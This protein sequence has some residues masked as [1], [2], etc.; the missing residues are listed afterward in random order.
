MDIVLADHRGFCYGVRRAVAL[1]T[2]PPPRLPAYTLGPIIHNPQL[3]A[4]LARQGVRPVDSISDIPAGTVIFRSH[5]VAPSAYQ[6]AKERGL[7]VVDATCPHV[8]KAQQAVRAFVEQ[9]YQVVV[10]GE[11]AHPEV[12][13]VIAWAGQPVQVVETVEDAARLPAAPRLAVV[14]QTTINASLLAAVV[15]VLRP[16]CQDLQVSHTICQATSQRQQAARDLAS[17]V[18]V[19]V[20]IGGKNSANTTRLAEL[21]RATGTPTYHVETADELRPAWFAGVKRAGV[22]AGAST[23]DWIIEEV[24]GR[25]QDMDQIYDV[26]PLEKD[27]VIKGTVVSVS[28]EGVVVDTGHKEEGLIPLHE[29]AYPVPA[30]P[31][32]VVKPGDEIEVYV[33]STDNGE[34]NVLLS[35]VKA[36]AM[37]TWEALAAALDEHRPLT[38]QVTEVVKGG[39]SVAVMGVRGFIPASQVELHFVADLTPYVGQEVTALPIEVDTQ[40]HKVVLSRRRYLE[41]ERQ[42]KAQEVFASIEAGQTRKGIVRRLTDYGA[43]VDLGGVDGLLHVS[44]MSWERVKNPAD[45]ISVGDEID[46]YILKKDDATGRIS[47][48]LKQTQRNPWY[49]A[50]ADLASGQILTGTVTKTTSFGAFVKLPTGVEGLVHISQLAKRRVAT[51]EE[52]VKQGDTVK[53]KIL[54]IDRER[55]RISLSIKAAEDDDDRSSYRSYMAGQHNTRVTLGDTLG[56]LFEKKDD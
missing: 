42:K 4:R 47:L 46:V 1:A 45:V 32:A 43:F 35:K 20:V 29:L 52:V 3:V 41:E 15:E 49:D 55:Q 39:L 14:A 36:D 56:H 30:D 26:K 28:N 44:E 31:A 13:S 12:Q 24:I 51:T 5:G 34:G 21:C 50:V 6:Q 18:E 25:M 8:R 9:G 38:C 17:Q 53:V 10:V 54:G 19:M 23:P 11:A 27:T 37:K 22:T 7:A 40:R 2:Q 48:S 33:L 16:K